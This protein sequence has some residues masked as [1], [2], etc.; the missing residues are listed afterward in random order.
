VRNLLK[1]GML[2]KTGHTLEGKTVLELGPG[3]TPDLLFA[4]LLY[5]AQ[6]TLGYD[7]S[8]YLKQDIHDLALYQETRAWITDAVE[9]GTLPQLNGLNLNRLEAEGERIPR[10]MLAVQLYD[11]VHIP[12]ESKSVDVI[13]SKSVLEHVQLPKALLEE[14]KRIL[15]P[16][17]VICHI[18]DL[19]DHG[20]FENGKDWLRFLRY[21]QRT[22][23]RMRSN[24]STWT[25]RVRSPQ[26]EAL[27]EE[28]PEHCHRLRLLRPIVTNKEL[29]QIN[30]QLQSLG[31]L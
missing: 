13:W 12:I 28:T 6:K 11:G 20:T 5:G 1:E 16:G 9:Q 25:N 4:A 29:E 2:Q 17:G 3:Q 15:R 31:A 7:V 21:E 24:R 8:E 14:M 19:R 18:I 23:D 22:W 27:L 30:L 26:W 10:G